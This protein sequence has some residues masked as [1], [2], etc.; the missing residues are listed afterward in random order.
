[1]R[2]ALLEFGVARQEFNAAKA[3]LS[4]AAERVTQLAWDAGDA[5]MM[6]RMHAEIPAEL[7]ELPAHLAE[8]YDGAIAQSACIDG[9][10]WAHAPGQPFRATRLPGLRPPVLKV[11]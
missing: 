1:M 3:R 9:E 7:I 5:I 10:W 2:R 6:D 8:V 4:K 11:C